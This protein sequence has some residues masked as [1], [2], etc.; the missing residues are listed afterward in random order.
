MRSAATSYPFVRPNRSTT[1]ARHLSLGC[2]GMALAADVL[3]AR[4]VAPTDVQV[5]GRVSHA[6]ARRAWH[7]HERW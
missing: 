1:F 7:R 3:R 4:G 2:M 5:D 6:M